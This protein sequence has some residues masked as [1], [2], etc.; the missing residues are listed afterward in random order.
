MVEASSIKEVLAKSQLFHGLPDRDLEKLIAISRP[1][2]YEAGDVILVEGAPA[3]HLY[4]IEEG[5]ISVEMRISI[6]SKVSRQ[7]T[8]DVIGAGAACGWSAAFGLHPLTMSTR[9]LEPTKVIVVEGAPLR[10]LLVENPP[11]GTLVVGRLVNIV[12]SRLQHTRQT[13][14]KV[15]SVVS[16]D[17]KSPLAAVQ[18]YNQVMLAGMA[19]ELTEKQRFMLQRNSERLKGFLK[20]IDDLLDISSVE[21]AVVDMKLVS[22]PDLLRDAVENMHPLAEEKGLQLTVESP[23]G[24]SLILGSAPRLQQVVNNLLDNAIKYTPAGGSVLVRL[25]EDNGNV[26]LEVCDTGIGISAE[27]LPHIFDDFY[28]SAASGSKGAGLGLSIARRVVAAHKGRIWAESPCPE[29]GKGSKFIV[30]LP[31][32]FQKG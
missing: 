21:T 17:L 12:F 10:R 9:C 20:L 31:K 7:S 19:G 3:A 1:E 13:L 11:M 16:H 32:I 6:G 23:A 30:V 18:S 26:K 8:I 24:L 15:L 4:V 28:R 25:S 27:D 14:A 5:R 2:A 22:M 29:T